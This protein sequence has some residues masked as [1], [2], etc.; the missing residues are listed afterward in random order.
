MGKSSDKVIKHKKGSPQNSERESYLVPS[1]R[2]NRM[3]C[4]LKGIL[5][6]DPEALILP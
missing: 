3:V 4:V 5:E 6:M 1:N 2:A